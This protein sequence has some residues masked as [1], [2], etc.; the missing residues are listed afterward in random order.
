MHVV[1]FLLLYLMKTMGIEVLG[2]SAMMFPR[3]MCREIRA[4][5]QVILCRE[6]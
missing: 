1:G 5:E 4:T 3:I 2:M 6:M